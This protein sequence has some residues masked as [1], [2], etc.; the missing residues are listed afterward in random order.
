MDSIAERYSKWHIDLWKANRMELE[1]AGV[2][3]CN[4][5]VSGICT[6]INNDDFFS[7]RRLGINSGR[8]ISGI[9]IKNK[10]V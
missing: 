1:S 9:M 3:S 4:I 6:Y 5:E 10:N 2:K 7:A 8:I